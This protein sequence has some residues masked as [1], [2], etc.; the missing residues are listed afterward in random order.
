MAQHPGLSELSA[1]TAYTNIVYPGSQD[2]THLPVTLPLIEQCLLSRFITDKVLCNEHYAVTTARIKQSETDMDF[3]KRLHD[4]AR[5]CRNV[6]SN[7]KLVN[8]FKQGLPDATSSLLE[9]NLRGIP[10]STLHDLYR[11][12]QYALTAVKAACACQAPS[13]LPSKRSTPPPTY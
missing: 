2:P 10:A 11:V 5:R 13:V 4:M 8:F 1:Q 9:D 6:F 3:G 12:K 7:A